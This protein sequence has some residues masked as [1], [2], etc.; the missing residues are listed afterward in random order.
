MRQVDTCNNRLPERLRPNRLH[1]DLAAFAIVDHAGRLVSPHLASRRDLLFD[2]PG[3]KI[4]PLSVHPWNK[5]RVWPEMRK[6][7]KNANN[8]K[9]VKKDANLIP[10][11][12]KKSVKE[13]TPVEYPLFY[14]IEWEPKALPHVCRACY[15]EEKHNVLRTVTTS[16]SALAQHSTI[17]G[18]L[19]LSTESR[20]K[21]PT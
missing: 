10:G 5:T 6:S 17:T 14:R 21:I 7:T 8:I 3:R 15:R 9:I 18:L 11:R 2:H 20:W 1:L 12:V 4:L 16:L 19:S 13:K